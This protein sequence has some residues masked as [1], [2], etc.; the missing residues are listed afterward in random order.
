MT[1]VISV[2]TSANGLSQRHSPPQA[3]ENTRCLKEIEDFF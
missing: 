3:K 1:V 2:I